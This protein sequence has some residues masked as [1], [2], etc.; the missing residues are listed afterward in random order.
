M[1]ISLTKDGLRL[2]YRTTVQTS[3]SGTYPIGTVIVT[4]GEGLSLP[5]TWIQI[6][7]TY[8]GTETYAGSGVGPHAMGV[9]VS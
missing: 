7:G 6:R 9:R 5:G 8:G 2:D 1:A 4:G 3:S